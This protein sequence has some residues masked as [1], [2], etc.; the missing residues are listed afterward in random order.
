M[1]APLLGGVG[2]GRFIGRTQ[3]H[4][5]ASRIR[6]SSPLKT[7]P[8]EATG[9]TIHAD[10]RGDPAG[11]LSSRGERDRR[12]PRQVL[13]CASFLALWQW[14]RA[15]QKRQRTGAVQD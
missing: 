12:R 2:G 8:G 3:I 14:G 15:N 7:P 4:T 13:E 9:P 5:Q 11:R 1:L 6:D 10:F